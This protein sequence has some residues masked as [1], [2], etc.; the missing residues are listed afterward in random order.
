MRGLAIVAAGLSLC[1][2]IAAGAFGVAGFWAGGKPQA[3]STIANPIGQTLIPHLVQILAAEN[4]GLVTEL[5]MF[6]HCGCCPCVRDDSMPEK[7]G[8]VDLRFDAPPAPT[9]NSPQFLLTSPFASFPVSAL[10]AESP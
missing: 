9:Y 5:S 2:T 6:C 1:A 3:P 7:T 10:P 8:N 4:F